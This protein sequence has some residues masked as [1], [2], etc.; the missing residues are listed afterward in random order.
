VQ[1]TPSRRA[2]LRLHVIHEEDLPGAFHDIPTL[3]QKWG[4]H[5]EPQECVWVVA[6][7]ANMTVRT[8]MEVA[9]GSHVR[10]EVHIPTLLASVLTTGCERFM[11]VHNHPSKRLVPS[12]GDRELTIEIMDAANACGLYFEDH[13]ILTPNGKWYSFE[14]HGLLKRADY[15]EHSG[16]ARKAASDR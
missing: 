14:E 2:E 1:A 15:I 11:L 8:V 12:L 6:Y 9:R 5:Q 16:A 7:D 3:F 4:L 13:V 10:A